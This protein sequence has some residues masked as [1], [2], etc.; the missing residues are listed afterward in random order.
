MHV[1]I[2]KQD[3]T[4]ESSQLKYFLPLIQTWGGKVLSMKTNPESWMHPGSS[5]GVCCESSTGVE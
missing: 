1:N 5:I 2:I 3:P 4:S